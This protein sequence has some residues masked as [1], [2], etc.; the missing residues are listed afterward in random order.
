MYQKLYAMSDVQ[1]PFTLCT[2]NPPRKVLKVGQQSLQD[3]G[4]EVSCLSVMEEGSSLDEDEWLD[5]LN[6]SSDSQVSGLGVLCTFV[7]GYACVVGRLRSAKSLVSS[8]KKG[9]LHV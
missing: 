4:K 1:P 7:Y 9:I 8:M 5:A 3:D 6:S 2:A